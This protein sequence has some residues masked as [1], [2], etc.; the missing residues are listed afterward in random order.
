M[1]DDYEMLRSV[2]T[3]SDLK[4]NL[5]KKINK[6]R[7]DAVYKKLD[8]PEYKKIEA[9]EL[10][11]IPIEK[12]LKRRKVS[13]NSDDNFDPVEYRRVRNEFLKNLRKGRQF[14]PSPP[15]AAVNKQLEAVN[16]KADMVEKMYASGDL[17]DEE[18]ELLMEQLDAEYD[19][20]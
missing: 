1:A 19:E 9:M 2:V 10:L 14:T 11:N 16:L 3:G 13:S 7:M 20:L 5:K 4:N 12:T 6:Q 17:T 15:K 8:V 18:F